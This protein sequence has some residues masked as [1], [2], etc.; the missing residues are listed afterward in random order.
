MMMEAPG[1]SIRFGDFCKSLFFLVI[2]NVFFV[3]CPE[4]KGELGEAHP[5]HQKL[6]GD[7]IGSIYKC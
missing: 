7:D 1:G 2:C 5:A 3:P 6:F 4:K